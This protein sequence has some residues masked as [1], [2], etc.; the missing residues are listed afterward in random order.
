MTN[1]QRLAAAGIT[2]P[3]AL[4]AAK[5]LAPEVYAQCV[6]DTDRPPQ[7]TYA[8]IDAVNIS[9]LKWMGVSPL[10]YQFMLAQPDHDTDPKRK[11]RLGHCAVFEPERLDRWGSSWAKDR[12]GGD[13]LKFRAIQGADY[14]WKPEERE[15]ALAISAAVHADPVAG[16]LVTGGRAERCREWT[17]LR[18]RVKCKGRL[19]YENELGISDLKV[20]ADM[21]D[22][23][24]Q[25]AICSFS[26]HAQ[27]AWYSDGAGGRP[28][29]WIFVEAKPPH[30][31][32]V[33]PATEDWLTIGRTLYDGWLD[34]LVACRASGVWPGRGAGKPREIAP[35]AYAIDYDAEEIEL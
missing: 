11:G 31:V 8:S 28:F 33:V 25:R 19:D 21:S 1:E 13:W 30:D 16:P 29:C 32:L 5:A 27:A 6:A 23:G 3:G 14:V 20:V 17:D 9:S 4:E 26:S 24:I 22:R 2:G 18:T 34:Q 7:T 10:R 15:H 12:R 35:P